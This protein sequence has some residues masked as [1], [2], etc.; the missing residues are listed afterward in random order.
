MTPRKP[1]LHD[2]AAAAGVSIAAASFALRDKAGVSPETRERVLAAARALGYVVNAPARSLRTARYGAIGLLLPPGAMRL[3][4]YT[5]FAFGVV[6][7]ADRRGLSVILLPH[8]EADDDTPPTAFVDGYVVVDGTTDDAGV[9]AI[10]DTGRP[11]ISAEHLVGGEGRVAASVVYDHEAALR[12]LLDH[13]ATRGAERIAAVLPSA[14]TAWSRELTATY[15]TWTAERGGI[16]ISRAIGFIP[17][18]EEVDAAVGDIL[19]TEHVDA[20][21][22]GPSGSAA[23]ALEAAHRAGRR[24]GDDLL[25]AA[26]V[27]EPMHALL[28]PTVTSFD[29]E[30]REVGEACLELFTAIQD[31]DPPNDRV[32]VRLPRLVVRASTAGR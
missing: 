4:Y 17:T 8:R 31:A 2:V 27:D 14:G 29:L 11:V 10:L 22:V 6:D 19:A 9:R 32:Q 23:P 12:L 28:S 26:Y 3:P 13:L 18:A 20:L 1:T 5:E 24:V 15:E 25:L 21:I 30:A 7:A 16:P